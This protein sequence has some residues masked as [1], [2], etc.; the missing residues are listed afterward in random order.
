MSRFLSCVYLCAHAE[1]VTRAVDLPVFVA[2]APQP[3]EKPHLRRMS[4]AD[5]PAAGQAQA[6]VRR[7]A[8]V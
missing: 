6:K 8:H 2:P 1:S 3:G 4:V 7:Y 5:R